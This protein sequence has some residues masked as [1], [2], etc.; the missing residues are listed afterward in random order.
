MYFCAPFSDVQGM[1][2]VMH[3]SW[4][5]ADY[6]LILFKD[7]SL[8]M[9]QKVDRL[10]VL[11]RLLTN[12]EVGSQE[13]LVSKLSKQGY[14]VTQATLSRDL[15]QLKAEKMRKGKG[16]V[17]VL[18]E[19][20]PYERISAS[21]Q[22]LENMHHNGF[23][24]IEYSGN[25]AVIHT[26]PGYAG[27]IASTIDNSKLTS[28][29]GTIAGDDTILVIIREGYDREKLYVELSSCLPNL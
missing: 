13:E 23:V 24:D 15:R 25:M 2:C 3:N 14:N 20:K 19:H 16:F 9:S 21:R 28:V 26:L 11:K 29:C 6:C 17:Y 12:T 1:N 4:H 27:V 18:P 10:T 5:L 8:I 7:N 22:K